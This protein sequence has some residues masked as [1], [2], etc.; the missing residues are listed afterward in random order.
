[1]ASERLGGDF[2]A[3]HRVSS[4]VSA[5]LDSPSKPTFSCLLCAWGN[6][7]F[8]LGCFWTWKWQVKCISEFKLWE[9]KSQDLEHDTWKKHYSAAVCCWA[10]ATRWP[11]DLA[12]HTTSCWYDTSTLCPKKGTWWCFV[13]SEYSLE[14]VASHTMNAVL[15]QTTPRLFL[16]VF[17]RQA[18]HHEQTEVLYFHR[19]WMFFCEHFST[20][21]GDSDQHLRRWSPSCMKKGSNLASFILPGPRFPMKVKFLI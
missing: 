4:C 9:K 8:N 3:D 17:T 11:W 5:A 13:T 10:D 6:S 20:V 1:M 16:V 7:L 2:Q 14:H 18:S 15:G 19:H 12:L 21:W